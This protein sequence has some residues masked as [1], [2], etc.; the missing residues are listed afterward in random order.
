MSFNLMTDHEIVKSLG[1]MFDQLRI[2]KQLQDKDILSASGTSSSVLAKFRSGKGNITLETF[3]KLMRA[4]NELDKLEN[5]LLLPD[6]YSPTASK[7]KQQKRVI[8]P[9]IKPK[10]NF[11][12]EEDK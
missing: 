10:L 8:K 6:V 9:A 2:H 3:V 7:D 4:V 1:K 11:V 12:W 5:L